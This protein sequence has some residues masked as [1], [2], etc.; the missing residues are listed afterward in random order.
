MNPIFIYVIQGGNRTVYGFYKSA[1]S[2]KLRKLSQIPKCKIVHKLVTDLN[3][4]DREE[5]VSRYQR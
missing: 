3:G 2:I 4:T 1:I 5:V